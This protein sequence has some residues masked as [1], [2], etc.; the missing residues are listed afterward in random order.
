V[1]K[2]MRH[3][4]KVYAFIYCLYSMFKKYVRHWQTGLRKKTTDFILYF[5]GEIYKQMPETRWFYEVKVKKTKQ[6]VEN[7]ML[8]TN[9]S[10]SYLTLP[11]RY[12]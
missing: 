10:L 7:P 9:T 8:S 5:K 3:T 11:P 1:L 12:I 4:L 6:L 2:E